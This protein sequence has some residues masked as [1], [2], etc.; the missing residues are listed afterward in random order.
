MIFSDR[1]K[2][3]IKQV[4]GTKVWRNLMARQRS[5]ISI[6]EI[7]L[8]ESTANKFTIFESIVNESIV[9]DNWT[10]VVNHSITRYTNSCLLHNIGGP[11]WYNNRFR[12]VRPM[13]ATIADFERAK[14]NIEKNLT[15]FRY[16]KGDNISE[17][18]DA[19]AR[20]YYIFHIVS[21]HWQG[22]LF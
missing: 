7:A 1:A 10:C 19:T 22:N 13:S 17:T 2:M 9:D 21:N 8:N 18:L 5:C 16:K 6:D 4:L 3:K 14:A 11:P 15:I 20:T 12:I